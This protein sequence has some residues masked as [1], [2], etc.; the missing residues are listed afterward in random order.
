VVIAC[1]Y[2][3]DD[4]QAPENS[5]VHYRVSIFF[6]GSEVPFAFTIECACKDFDMRDFRVNEKESEVSFEI[7]TDGERLKFRIGRLS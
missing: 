5:F 6:L 3:H 4:K 7:L 1:G 2:A